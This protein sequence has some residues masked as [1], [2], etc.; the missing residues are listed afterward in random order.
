MGD[1]GDL[2]R[3]TVFKHVGVIKEGQREVVDDLKGW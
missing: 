2:M 1:G 3:G